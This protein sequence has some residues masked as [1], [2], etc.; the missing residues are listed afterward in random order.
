MSQGS[1]YLEAYVWPKYKDPSGQLCQSLWRISHP[2]EDVQTIPKW[3]SELIETPIKS[4]LMLVYSSP[5]N[6]I[7]LKEPFKGF[8]IVIHKNRQGAT[9]PMN[10]QKIELQIH[11]QEEFAQLSGLVEKAMLRLLKKSIEFGQG[12][13]IELENEDGQVFCFPRAKFKF[14]LKELGF[15]DEQILNMSVNDTIEAAP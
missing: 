15:S 13:V 10:Q 9:L 2:K 1:D 8:S 12:D 5:K 4:L 7:V 14:Y 3:F 11:Q 6:W